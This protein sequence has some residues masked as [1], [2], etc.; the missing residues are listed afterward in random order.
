M[1]QPLKFII[2]IFMCSGCL[3]SK[4]QEYINPPG[5]DKFQGY[6]RHI[7]GAD[8]IMLQCVVRYVAFA[9]NQYVRG[10]DFYYSYKQGNQFIKGSATFSS[11]ANQ[12]DFGG[13]KPYGPDLD[14]L[15][16]GG[17]DPL[18]NKKEEG[19]LVINAAGTQLKYVR[20]MNIN[21]GGLRTQ[22]LPGWTLPSGIVFTRYTIPPTGGD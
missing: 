21:G 6:Y 3:Q 15:V 16:F 1:K 18:K 19:Y 2:I 12:Y 4:A 14:K 20:D 10:A 11:T 17:L 13:T 7:N 22:G 8:T 5:L 9:D